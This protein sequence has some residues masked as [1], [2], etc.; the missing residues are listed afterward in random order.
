MTTTTN[1]TVARP[2][3]VD[4]LTTQAALLPLVKEF[5]RAMKP[6]NRAMATIAKQETIIDLNRALAGRIFT[7]VLAV[8]AMT[9]KSG[10]PIASK[11]ATA[12]GMGN[13]AVALW[14]KAAGLVMIQVNA[15]ELVLEETP[16]EAEIELFNSPWR[17]AAQ[18][19][20]ERRAAAKAA[21]GEATDGETP[22]KDSRDTDGTKG[23]ESDTTGLTFADI[24]V[25]VNELKAT[26]DLAA[27]NNVTVTE[28]DN[29]SL[30]EVMAGIMATLGSMS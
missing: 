27:R 9:N 28:S 18:S 16:S 23:G 22:D 21:K 15:G 29:E 7:R 26:V 1:E 13:D 2:L 5:D 25:K 14:I 8:P 19:K 12:L 3:T 4:E 6:I 30:N 11:I 17:D 10:K 24:M 20:R